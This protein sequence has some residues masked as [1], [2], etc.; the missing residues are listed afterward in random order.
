MKNEKTKKRKAP[1]TKEKYTKQCLAYTKCSINFSYYTIIS[2]K[3]RKGENHE[4]YWKRFHEEVV[5]T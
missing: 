2:K 5:E 1:S 4:I 3:K